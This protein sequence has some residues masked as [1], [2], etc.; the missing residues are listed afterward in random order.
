[1]KN[2]F[3]VMALSLVA[4]LAQASVT[5]TRCG[6]LENNTPANYSLVDADGEWR[7]G[8]QG[9]YQAKGI[10]NL[11]AV[12][13]S[14]F[15]A[16][17]GNYGRSCACLDVK[18]DAA[19]ML[20]KYIAGG[21]TRPLSECYSSGVEPTYPK[22]PQRPAPAPAPAPRPKQPTPP[23]EDPNGPVYPQPK[24]PRQPEQPK[25]PDYGQKDPDYGQKDPSYPADPRIPAPS[26]EI[27]IMIDYRGYNNYAVK[28]VSNFDQVV[29]A[30]YLLPTTLTPNG[31]CYKGN[32]NDAAAL[33]NEMVAR[34]NYE[35]NRHVTADVSVYFD[36][37]DTNKPVLHVN[38]Y[39]E[40]TGPFEW[41]P[42]IR[43]C[44]RWSTAEER[45]NT[46]R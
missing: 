30:A 36:A 25:A 37:G 10:E 19:P 23:W 15:E 24:E 41:F 5:E 18:V 32:P 29:S 20:V 6:W 43:Q 22:T 33:F 7:I 12:D 3:A 14:Q 21:E 34:L 1:M 16:T 45:A 8:V 44:D 46:P 38:A 2:I 40:I 35:G 4:P 9:G 28:Y 13:P 31:A 11:P 27:Q 39:D 42:R 17:N 26:A